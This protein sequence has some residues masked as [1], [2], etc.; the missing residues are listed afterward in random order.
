MYNV[1]KILFCCILFQSLIACSG[2]SSTPEPPVK[3]ERPSANKAVDISSGTATYLGNEAVMVEHAGNKI[4][5]D[6][7]FHNGFNI[8]QTVPEDIRE[9]IFSGT[10]PY[11]NID[12]IFISH[13]H[14]DHFSADDMVDFLLEHEITQLIAPQQAIDAVL[15]LEDFEDLSTIKPRL[16][17]ITLAY[18]DTPV[19][20]KI[21]DLDIDAVRIPH[22]GWPQRAEV[23]NIVFRVSLS[24]E[25]TVI[26]MGDADA[27]DKHFKP[28][29]DHW[30]KTITNT[31]FPP[32]WFF[33]SD[34]GKFIL[35]DRINAN[36]SIGIHVPINVP[37][38]LKQSGAD[39][40]SKPSE[41]RVID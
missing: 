11:D 23:A 16:H 7:F 36:E 35:N 30:K 20:L 10:A 38:E 22:A 32:Y 3:T 39:Y 2:S 41:S 33:F 37:V 28:L 26:H 17:A 19:E 27:N 24:N 18:K 13:A 4:L 25:V 21:G 5:F 15:E 8:Y 29:L 1:I 14:A 34:T 6:P 9:A 12:A 40:F 31:A